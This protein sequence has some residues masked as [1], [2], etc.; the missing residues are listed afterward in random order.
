MNLSFVR[1]KVIGILGAPHPEPVMDSRIRVSLE[2]LTIGQADSELRDILS[3]LTEAGYVQTEDD[4]D[5]AEGSFQ[6]VFLTGKG[7]ALIRGD[8]SDD[9]IDPRAY[10]AV[11]RMEKFRR[12]RRT[13]RG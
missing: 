3:Y 13:A 2:D 4:Y 7:V 8:V 6:R 5:E 10:A 9:W 1:G 12:Q 11:A